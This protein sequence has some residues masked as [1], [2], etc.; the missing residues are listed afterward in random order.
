MTV[1]VE[2][3]AVHFARQHEVFIIRKSVELVLVGRAGTVVLLG[4]L[5]DGFLNGVGT[6]LVLQVCFNVILT[7]RKKY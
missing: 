2:G 4:F 6:L 5:L 7:C 3:A 1:L